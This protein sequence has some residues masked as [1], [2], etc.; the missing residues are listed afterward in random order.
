MPNTYVVTTSRVARVAVIFVAVAA[1]MLVWTQLAYA[2]PAP[3]PAPQPAGGAVNP[4]DGVSPDISLFGPA[5]NQ[6]WKRFLAAIWGASIAICA[7]W[8]MTSFLKFRKARGRNMP[9][10]LSDAS[11]DLRLSLYA[12]G[13]VAGISPIIGAALMLVQPAA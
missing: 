4:F 2:Q 9:S 6:T 13:G 5:L 3:T 8:V 10:D 7:F 1:L 11:D 12:L